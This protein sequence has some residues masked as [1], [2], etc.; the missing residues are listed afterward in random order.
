MPEVVEELFPEVL[1]KEGAGVGVGVAAVLGVGLGFKLAMETGVAVAD[2]TLAGAAVGAGEELVGAV[3]LNGVA[4]A[5]GVGE[6]IATF[7]PA[8][9]W[10]SWL[11]LLLIA[12][13]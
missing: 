1:G 4:V 9:L 13:E 5:T 3:R 11:N 2:G 8:A 7:S 6:T 10:R 12:A